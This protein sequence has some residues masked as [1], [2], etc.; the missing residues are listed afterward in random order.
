VAA[1]RAALS[2]HPPLQHA[3]AGMQ[4]GMA[5]PVT[6]AALSP[7]LESGAVGVSGALRPSLTPRI[8]DHSSII[9]LFEG[10]P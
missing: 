8:F 2:R 3:D 4:I 1:W 5:S 10:L 9:L 7:A 6:Y